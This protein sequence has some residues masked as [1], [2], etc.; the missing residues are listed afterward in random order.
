M[1]L[2]IRN[3]TP[4]QKALFQAGIDA[5]GVTAPDPVARSLLG[6]ESVSAFFNVKKRLGDANSNVN[7]LIAGD[8]TSTY[9]GGSPGKGWSAQFIDALVARYPAFTWVHRYNYNAATGGYGVTETVKTGT[10]GRTVIV[11]NTG[12]GGTIPAHALGSPNVGQGYYPSGLGSTGQ[13]D[14]I[15][16]D[17]GFNGTTLAQMLATLDT[18]QSW[19]MKAGVVVMEQ[20]PIYGSNNGAVSSEN[21]RRLAALKNATII[22]AETLF[23]AAGKPATWYASTAATEVHPSVLGHANIT[24][25]MLGL[26]DS[27]VEMRFPRAPTFNVTTPNL[28]PNGNFATY[29]AGTLAG[30]SATNATLAENTTTY[31]TGGRSI[32]LTIGTNADSYIDTQITDTGALRRL[33]RQTVT[34]SA[35][36]ILPATQ[37]STSCRLAL[38]YNG[39]E[40]AIADQPFSNASSVYD[41]TGGGY[42]LRVVQAQLPEFTNLALPLTLRFYG[43]KGTDANRSGAGK[44]CNIGY[45]KLDIG[46][47]PYGIG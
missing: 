16:Y 11:Y 39:A 8:S 18:I 10:N 22:P 35:P 2:D 14:L 47:Y 40:I 42:V 34:L 37:P 29:S 7:I 31:I 28:V 38:L 23:L 20:W 9:G 6:H 43:Q 26:F 41:Q 44:I 45:M 19:H 3:L 13:V 24:S 46:S 33:S 12:V 36:I 15:I 4:A 32:D 1:A 21:A 27:G 25:L 17:F 30:F 5:A